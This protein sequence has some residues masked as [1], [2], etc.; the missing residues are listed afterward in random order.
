[1]KNAQYNT[2][3]CDLHGNLGQ[4]RAEE[5][6]DKHPEKL[7]LGGLYST[8]DGDYHATWKVAEFTL[9]LRHLGGGSCGFAH[10]GQL[11]IN[12]YVWTKG[13]FPVLRAPPR[14]G[15]ATTMDLMVWGP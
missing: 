2:I 12:T 8:V 15:F 4:H 11:L 9:S 1:M 6:I 10:T 3:C 5:M 7:V 13:S 14:E